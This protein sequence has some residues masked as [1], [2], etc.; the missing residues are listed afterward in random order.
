MGPRKV[1]QTR[2]RLDASSQ[3]R[4]QPRLGLIGIERILAD[5]V[6]GNSCPEHA[7]GIGTRAAHRDGQTVRRTLDKVE[8][9]ILQIREDRFVRLLRRTESRRDFLLRQEM[10]KFF[11][12]G[13]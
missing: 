12:C 2:D 9:A 13:S 10:W 5:A 8:A 3:S 1:G 6:I 4:R 7:L 11:E